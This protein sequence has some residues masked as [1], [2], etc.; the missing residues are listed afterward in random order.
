M[1]EILQY[2]LA[3]FILLAPLGLVG[4]WRWSTYLFKVQKKKRYKPIARN[5]LF[6][7]KE[8]TFVVPVYN[9]EPQKFSHALK[10]W[11]R[12]QPKLIILVIDHMDTA[13]LEVARWYQQ[14]APVP[15]KIIA[16]E[17]RGKREALVDG[18]KEVRTAFVTLIDSDTFFTQEVIKDL[19]SPFIDKR[20][21]GVA[22]RQAVWKPLTYVQKAYQIQLA[23]RYEVEMPFMDVG[24]L[25]TTCISG[26]TAMY[27]TSAIK[28]RLH[29][30]ENEYFLGAKCISGDDKCLTRIVQR[31]DW[32]V[33]YQ[34]TALVWTHAAP[35]LSTYLKQRIRWTR[36]SWRSDLVALIM[37]DGW[38]YRNR[39]LAFHTVDRFVQPFTLI[40]GP[41]FFFTALLNGFYLAGGLFLL[42]IFFTRL[43]KLQV[44]ISRAP[45]LLFVIP[46]YVLLTYIIA[47]LK[48]YAL[49][50]IRRQG[51]ITRWSKQRLKT[52]NIAEIL[53]G[54]VTP[55][56]ATAVTILALAQGVNLFYDKAITVAMANDSYR[57]R[58]VDY[59]DALARATELEES[60]RNPTGLRTHVL[61][62]GETLPL[63]ARR[64][65]VLPGVITGPSEPTTG[66]AL[67][68]PIDALRTPN[69]VIDLATRPTSTYTYQPFSIRGGGWETDHIVSENIVYLS[70]PGT[71][72]SIDELFTSL[73]ERYGDSVVEDEG[74]GTWLLKA[75]I[76]IGKDATLYFP[77]QLVKWVKLYSTDTYFTWITSSD[78][79][80]HIEDTRITSWDPTI[81]SYDTEHIESGRSFILAKDSGRM[82]VINSEIA[83]LGYTSYRDQP[84]GYPFGGSYGLSWK[85]QEGTLD[86]QIVTGNVIG[87]KIHHN[88][89]GVYTFGSVGQLMQDNEVYQNVEYGFDPHDDSNHL[90]IEDNFVYENGNHGII[91][92]KRCFNILIANNTSINNA[93]H[94]VML[95]QATNRNLVVGNTLYGN[96]DGVV[97]LDS[98]ENI[99]HSNDIYDNRNAGIRI[100]VFSSANTAFDNK[101][102]QNF[103]GIYVYDHS[104]D[105]HFLRNTISLNDVGIHL[106]NTSFNSFIE[107]TKSNNKTPIQL[108]EQSLRNY[109]SLGK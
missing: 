36:N 4:I 94:G 84:R 19:L 46:H 59:N 15:I 62:F 52:P 18:I 8:V 47:V 25:T 50:T 97:V 3:I 90:I 70:G 11:A 92:S 48:I 6:S 49:Y 23:E 83:Y 106:R 41:V 99:I 72:I 55:I 76:A 102:Y 33:K 17:R 75:S 96:E 14:R 86:K 51:W 85:L 65:N 45:M 43:L 38:I 44:H 32:L 24:G 34:S 93:L 67:R 39:N 30:L 74:D 89:F 53:F 1:T 57:S 63:I 40:L 27:R 31:N 82:D 56:I 69:T 79:G 7:C 20:I 104:V 77:G 21:G 105:N 109:I 29:E 54:K 78:G 60:V 87:N 2:N 80:I 101:V 12:E 81:G 103:K 73:K 10:T 22:P 108:H 71:A 9:E 42:W 35:K 107:N 95:D 68:I 66:D 37:E 28:N 5:N 58:A 100:N 91:A 16:T 88:T 98:H 64:Y 26:R 61:K 13:C